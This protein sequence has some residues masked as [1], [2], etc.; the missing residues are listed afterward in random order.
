MASQLFIVLS[1]ALFAYT[2]ASPV[3]ETTE[4]T[5]TEA[6]EDVIPI[7]A[8]IEV[9]QPVPEVVAF[10]EETT[11]EAATEAPH[12]VAKRSLR[13]DNPS[14]DLLSQY[15]GNLDDTGLSSLAGRRIK[16]LPTWA[17]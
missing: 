1:L 17:G 15:E 8:V 12:K 7:Y 11:T 5:T 4:A 6:D 10:V 14:N 16:F 3:P 2:I 9:I 13:G